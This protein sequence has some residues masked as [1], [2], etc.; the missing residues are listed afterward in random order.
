MA[1]I[2]RRENILID[3]GLTATQSPGFIT[4]RAVDWLLNVALL[5]LAARFILRFFGANPLNSFVNII[6]TTTYPIVAPFASLFG[7]SRS[8]SAPAFEVSTLL[9]MVVVGI[10]LHSL[11]RTIATLTATPS[12]LMEHKE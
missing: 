1:H 9:A 7:T 3:Y 4:Q 6:Y 12:Y 11:I 10:L 8:L 5:L 2:L